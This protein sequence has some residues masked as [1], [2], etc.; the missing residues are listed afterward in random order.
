MIGKVGVELNFIPYP[1]SDKKCYGHSNGESA[2]VEYGRDFVF[3]DV[4]P[5]GFQTIVHDYL[6]KGKN[7][8]AMVDGRWSMV[9]IWP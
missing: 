4:S 5:A 7:T 9:G 3:P 1:Q 8:F 2:N 6:F